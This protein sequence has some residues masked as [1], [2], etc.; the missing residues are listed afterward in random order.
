MRLPSTVASF[1]YE[2]LISSTVPLSLPISTKSPTWN[3]CVVRSVTLPTTLESAFCTASEMASETTLR[4]ATSDVTSTPREL[5]A[6]STR[7]V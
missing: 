6:T 1:V 7:M 2:T 3:G 4:M 5:A